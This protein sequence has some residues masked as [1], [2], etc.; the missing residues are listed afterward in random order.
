MFINVTINLISFF[1]FGNIQN[2]IVISFTFIS[3]TPTLKPKERS[4]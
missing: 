4:I 1:F 3:Y 2:S